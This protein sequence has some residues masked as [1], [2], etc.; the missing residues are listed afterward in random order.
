M[1]ELIKDYLTKRAKKLPFVKG[2]QGYLKRSPM[3]KEMLVGG[4]GGAIATMAVMPIDTIS[5]TQKQWRMTKDQPELTQASKSFLATAKELA[6]PKIREGAKGGVRP[7]YAGAP[8]KLM[9]VVPSMALTF[10]GKQKIE[11]LLKK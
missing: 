10:A 4:G 7:F 1:N 6:H 3:A 5:D 2:I 11:G 9:K 8:G